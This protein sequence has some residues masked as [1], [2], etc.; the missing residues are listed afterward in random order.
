L[1][2]I[3]FLILVSE[4]VIRHG[5][6]TFQSFIF[7]PRLLQRTIDMRHICFTNMSIE[8]NR[9]PLYIDTIS[10]PYKTNH[11]EFYQNDKQTILVE[12]NEDIGKIK[13]NILLKKIYSLYLKISLRF[14]QI[15]ELIL[16]MIDYQ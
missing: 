3:L 1:K 14:S 2:R 4:R 10:M 13:E 16:N 12:Y 15:F 5:E 9:I 8:I 11:F 6:I 7:T